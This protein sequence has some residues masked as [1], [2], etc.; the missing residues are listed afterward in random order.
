MSGG[1]V[2]TMEVSYGAAAR[3]EGNVKTVIV[4]AMMRLSNGIVRE[5]KR[6]GASEGDGQV[7]KTRG[8]REGSRTEGGR[9]VQGD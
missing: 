3:E 2:V 6:I 1:Q 8:A 5:I 4:A 7:F 9:A